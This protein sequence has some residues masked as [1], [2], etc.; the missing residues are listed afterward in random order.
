MITRSVKGSL[1]LAT[2]L[3]LA[4]LTLAYASGQGWIDTDMDK[5]LVQALIGA[6]LVLFGNAMGKRAPD[7]AA[8]PEPHPGMSA[9]RRFFGLALVVG[10]LVHALSWLFAPLSMANWLSMGAVVLAMLAGLARVAMTLRKP[11]D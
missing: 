7:E 2:G 8:R 9:A 5:R 11:A 4:A 3:V 6:I 1:V 10:G